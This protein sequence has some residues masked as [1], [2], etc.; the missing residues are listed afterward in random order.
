MASEKTGEKSSWL[1]ISPDQWMRGEALPD[2]EVKCM[3]LCANYLGGSWIQV[4]DHVQDLE[5]RRI[6]GGLTN[7]LY[8]VGLRQHIPT[9]VDEPRE[10]AIKFY[11]PKLAP[12]EDGHNERLSD[13]IIVLLASQLGIG[14]R[15]YGLF[16]EGMIQSYHQVV[17]IFL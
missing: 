12:P 6:T 15:I 11:Q 16:D 2:V 9:E 10:V 7:Q 13:V 17:Y 3:K 5:V 1:D 4:T 8:Y 14:P